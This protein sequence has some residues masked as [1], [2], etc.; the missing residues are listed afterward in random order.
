M[1]TYGYK[2][3]HCEHEFELF[4]S[5]TASSRRTCPECGKRKLRRLIGMGA[6]ILF[7]GTGFYQ[8][9]Y[10][11]ESYK[12]AAEKDK[13]STEDTTKKKSSDDKKKGASSDKKEANSKKTG[14]DSSAEKKSA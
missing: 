12:K 8:T 4:Q 11:S 10:R 2:C 1:P 14:G 3:D 6:G 7:K 13:K 5:I 9:D